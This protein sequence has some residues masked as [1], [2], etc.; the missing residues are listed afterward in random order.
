[1]LACPRSAAARAPVPAAGP[2]WPVPLQEM[3]KHSKAGLARSVW[4]LW[5][6]V[7]SFIW[8]LCVSLVGMG[9]DSKCNFSPHTVF[10]R[11]LLCSWMWSIFFRWHPTFSCQWLV[12]IKLQF[13]SSLRRGWAHPSIL[14]SQALG[15]DDGQGSLACC[16]LFAWGCKQLD[17]TEQLNWTD[18]YLLWENLY[19][20]PIPNFKQ[21][22]FLFNIEFS[23][24]ILQ[25]GY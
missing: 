14:P 24:F 19:S 6:L 17:A 8:A 15:V 23:K 5:V 2:C 25:F 21:V 10:L 1:M 16:R 12:S 7:C 20:D 9:F 18:W 13:W 3:L 4:G 11:F 22:F